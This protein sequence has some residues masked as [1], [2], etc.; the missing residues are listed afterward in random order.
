[1]SNAFKLCFQFQLAPIHPGRVEHAVFLREAGADA[2]V[3]RCRLTPGCPRVDRIWYQRMMKLTY[4]EALSN[5]AFNFHLR[6][7]IGGQDLGGKD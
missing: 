4:D 1:M 6:R 7:Y 2:G 3:G 5:V